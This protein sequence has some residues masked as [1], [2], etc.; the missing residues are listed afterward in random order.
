MAE[1]PAALCMRPARETRARRGWATVSGLLVLYFLC[2]VR[3]FRKKDMWVKIF[4]PA[5]ARFAQLAPVKFLGEGA[6][7]D[8]SRDA[9][10][11]LS[12]PSTCVASRK[13]LARR[14]PRA[15]RPRH[16]R[17]RAAL[18]WRS[19]RCVSP[20]HQ[21]PDPWNW[22]CPRAMC[23]SPRARL[24]ARLGAHPASIAR[25]SRPIVAASV[26]VANP[27]ERG[28]CA[29]RARG[30]YPRSPPIPGATQ[31]SGRETSL[32]VRGHDR[33]HIA[34]RRGRA[35]LIAPR[36]FSPRGSLALCAQDS[37]RSRLEDAVLAR[38]IPS[39]F[40]QRPLQ[41]ERRPARR[42]FFSP[43]PRLPELATDRHS[44]RPS[45]SIRRF[46]VSP[47]FP[48]TI[49]PRAISN[50]PRVSSSR[51]SRLLAE[52]K[53]LSTTTTSQAGAYLAARPDRRQFPPTRP[54]VPGLNPVADVT[55]SPRSIIRRVAASTGTKESPVVVTSSMP[56]RI[57]GAT[58]PDDD[59]IVHWGRV[60][61]GKPPVK[62]G[63]E[64]FVHK[65]E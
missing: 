15:P 33:G 8:T 4:R 51:S 63:E 39:R 21:L 9:L 34:T 23:F 42:N 62:I 30:L 61:A 3:L 6:V 18:R 48:A 35:G 20:R 13:F 57:V 11:A 36:V 28:A 31:P 45:L 1:P 24:R 32:R 5:R 55:F 7:R 37:S 22:L 47:L 50:T 27:S 41:L 44:D 49:P 16:W 2:T 56:Y 54:D 64:W 65:A 38:G 19:R 60:E 53:G 43:V 26:P 40:A 12:S 52:G 58:D 46:V 14:L 29:F 25:N 10:R 17:P 59:S